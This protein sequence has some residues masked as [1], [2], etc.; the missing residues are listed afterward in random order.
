MLFFVYFGVAE[1]GSPGGIGRFEREAPF[2]TEGVVT[3]AESSANG[4]RKSRIKEEEIRP[5]RRIST[6]FCIVC[7]FIKRFV[8]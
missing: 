4:G 3:Y 1:Y 6:L 5:K 7:I 8:V 2:A